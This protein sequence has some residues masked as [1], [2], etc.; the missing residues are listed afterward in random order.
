M[1][2]V[3]LT[4]SLADAPAVGLVPADWPIGDA[5]PTDSAAAT[6]ARH[7]RRWTFLEPSSVVPTYAGIGVVAIGF[8]LI[9]I[10]WAEVAGLLKV[11]LQVPY[12]V[13][14]GLTGLALVMV[15]LVIVSVAV[16][17][18][19]AAERTRQLERLT[20]VLDDLRRALADSG[21]QQ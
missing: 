20:T 13:S 14:A 19:D 8:V 1:T 16:K 21:D 10:G 12:L 15:G 18:Q 7:H 3:I 9:A 4:D 5:A 17:R 11:A 6:P 2:N